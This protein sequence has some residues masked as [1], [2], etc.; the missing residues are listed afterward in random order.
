MKNITWA[1]LAIIIIAGGWYWLSMPSPAIPEAAMPAPS[2]AAGI[3]GSPDQGNLGQPD[4]GQVQKPTASGDIMAWTPEPGGDG[5]IEPVVGDNITLGTDGN[6][7]LGTYL[8]G[9]TGMPVYTYAKDTGTTSTCTGACTTNWPPYVVA[10]VDIINH[11]K[12]GVNGTVGTTTIPT[13]YVSPT[14]YTIQLTYNGHPLYFYAG[15]KSGG[16]PTGNGKGGVWAVVKP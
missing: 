4:N 6:A 14:G 15:D 10:P 16:D 8:I 9:Y 13:G 1:V 2:G 7:P 5:Y 12:S 3:N 11:L